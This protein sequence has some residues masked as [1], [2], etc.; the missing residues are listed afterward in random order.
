MNLNLNLNLNRTKANG[1]PLCDFHTF[2]IAAPATCDYYAGHTEALVP[3]L[4]KE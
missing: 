1:E 4:Q 2:A 3:K